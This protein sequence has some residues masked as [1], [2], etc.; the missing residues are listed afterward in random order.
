MGHAWPTSRR[1]NDETTALL[2]QRLLGAATGRLTRRA[3]D[4]DRAHGGWSTAGHAGWT[5]HLA[6]DSPEPARLPVGPWA[7]ARGRG[8]FRPSSPNGAARR[9]PD[10]LAP[11][12]ATRRP[13]AALAARRGSAG[14]A[15]RADVRTAGAVWPAIEPPADRPGKLCHDRARPATSHL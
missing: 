7:C 9:A 6:R 2:A 5:G 12:A 11:A 1:C 4:R 13:A 14:R 15:A 8:G 3:A 10:G